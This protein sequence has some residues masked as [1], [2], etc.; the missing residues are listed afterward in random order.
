LLAVLA[1]YG[2]TDQRDAQQ[3]YDAGVSQLQLTDL[4]PTY[5]VP[6][7][8]VLA[9]EPAWPMLDRLSWPERARLVE[10]LATVARHDGV[11]SVTELEL[12]RLVCGMLHCPLPA[13]IL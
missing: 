3:A 7:E 2:H 9:L 8:G 1:G 6:A 10:A 12:L 11:V 4:A 13:G 5:R